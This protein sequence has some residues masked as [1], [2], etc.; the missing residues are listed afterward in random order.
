[1]IAKDILGSSFNT[2]ESVNSNEVSSTNSLNSSS[3]ENAE[4]LEN[5]LIKTFQKY[6]RPTHAIY[7]ELEER[8]GKSRDWLMVISF[9]FSTFL[10]Q[11]S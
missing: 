6:R 1:V 2:A 7:T 10:P 4:I 5:F 3:N 9:P 11:D 8:T